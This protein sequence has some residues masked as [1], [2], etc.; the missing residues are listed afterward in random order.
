[1]SKIEP[2][3]QELLLVKN[4]KSL[5]SIHSIENI[6]QESYFTENIMFIIYEI[7]GSNYKRRISRN[8][9][10]YKVV[11]E[12]TFCFLVLCLRQLHT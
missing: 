10:F 5:G 6:D 1:M 11:R 12:G 9:F 2:M 3:N 8:G 7:S 4:Q